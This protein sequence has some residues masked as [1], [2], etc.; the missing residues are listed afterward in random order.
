[1]SCTQNWSC[2]SLLYQSKVYLYFK[3]NPNC[4]FFMKVLVIHYSLSVPPSLLCSNI[5]VLMVGKE[6]WRGEGTIFMDYNATIYMLPYLFLT[7][8][9]LC[10]IRLILRINKQKHNI[11]NKYHSQ[12]SNWSLSESKTFLF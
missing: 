3:K 9:V 10:Y 1:M 4:S 5:I 12:D 2:Q 11:A 6:D 7:K 8:I